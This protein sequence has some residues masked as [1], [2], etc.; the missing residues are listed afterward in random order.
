MHSGIS[1]HDSLRQA[2]L[3][4]I[5]IVRYP[6]TGLWSLRRAALFGTDKCLVHLQK[7][8]VSMPFSVSIPPQKAAPVGLLCP[9]SDRSGQSLPTCAVGMGLP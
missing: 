9:Q 5:R 6:T 8:C 2:S 1:E 3:Q 4:R 7:G